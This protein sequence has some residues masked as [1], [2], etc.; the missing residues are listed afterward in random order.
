M[1]E[2]TGVP[3]M[4]QQEPRMGMARAKQGQVAMV[5]AERADGRA[6]GHVAR[7]MRGM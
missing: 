6:G 3:G 4:L 1:G 7:D 5:W 2:R